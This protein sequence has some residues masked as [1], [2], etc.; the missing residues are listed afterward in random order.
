MFA[1]VWIRSGFAFSLQDVLLTLMALAVYRM[2][3]NCFGEGLK[4]NTAGVSGHHEGIQPSSETSSV[5]LVL[6]LSQ[7]R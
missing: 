1:G 4:A 2:K 5:L 3:N 7:P 6:W